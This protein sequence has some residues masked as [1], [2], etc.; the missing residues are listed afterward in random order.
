MKEDRFQQTPITGSRLINDLR[1]LNVR[2][3]GVLMIHCAMSK[4][5]WVVGGTQT[6]VEALLEILGPEGTLV[7][8]TR[9]PGCATTS[10][11]PTACFTRA[12]GICSTAAPEGK[13][14]FELSRRSH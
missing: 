5:G 1:A 13:G 4:I 2:V 3:G 7:A 14:R 12:F 10:P 8:Y 6:V 11:V 9:T